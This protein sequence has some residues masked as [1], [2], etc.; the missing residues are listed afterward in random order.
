[1]IETRRLKNV[2]S[3]QTILNFVLSRKTKNQVTVTLKHIIVIEVSVNGSILDKSES[4]AIY[5]SVL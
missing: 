5:H 4:L 2:I 3:I 1:M